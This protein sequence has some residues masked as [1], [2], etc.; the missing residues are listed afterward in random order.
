M[1]KWRSKDV[2]MMEGKSGNGKREIKWIGKRESESR[3]W[4]CKRKGE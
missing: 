4:K 1:E 2:I 3:D